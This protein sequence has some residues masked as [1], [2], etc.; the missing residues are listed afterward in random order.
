MKALMCGD[1]VRAALRPVSLRPE[2]V[3][4][5]L[6]SCLEGDE[7]YL[8]GSLA[9]GLGNAGS[10]VDLHVFVQ[11]RAEGVVPMLFFADRTRLDLVHYESG[12][13]ATALARTPVR[14]VALLGGRCALGPVPPMTDMKRLSRW[15]TAVPLYDGAPPIFTAEETA[16]IAAALVRLAVD[17]AVRAA[18]LAV[19][20]AAARAP[21]AGLAWS[22]AAERAVEAAVRARGEIFVGDK[23]LPAKAR[24]CGFPPALLADARR[25]TTAAD[26]ARYADRLGLRIGD[27]AALVR[28]TPAETPDFTFGDTTFQLVGEHLLHPLKLSTD[29]LDDALEAV[30]AAAL[31]EAITYGA[32][33]LAADPAAVD[34]RLA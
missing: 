7:V 9:A 28:L 29:S 21:L 4:D 12:T 23:W 18:A 11:E 24:R 3:I 33:A 20:M 10:D 8:V 31:A 17:I 25:V 27:P 15:A 32:I 19:V 34:G 2:E 1:A 6:G 13:P 30:D 5:V 26:F 16:R 14:D 22:R